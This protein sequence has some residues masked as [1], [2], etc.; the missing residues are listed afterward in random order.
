MIGIGLVLELEA[1]ELD[2]EQT[3]VARIRKAPEGPDLRAGIVR[4]TRTAGE[5]VIEGPIY[6]NAA[7]NLAVEFAEVGAHEI[8]IRWEDFLLDVVRF[9]VKTPG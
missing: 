8:Q 6:V 3:V 9:T 7:M 1:G 5:G 4:F 2:H